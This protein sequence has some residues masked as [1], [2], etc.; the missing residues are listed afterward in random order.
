MLDRFI[1]N[2]KYF[3]VNSGADIGFLPGYGDILNSDVYGEGGQFLY[4]M[5]FFASLRITILNLLFGTFWTHLNL[6][7]SYLAYAYIS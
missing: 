3:I 7:P 4:N 6:Y 2:Q 5:F 1:S